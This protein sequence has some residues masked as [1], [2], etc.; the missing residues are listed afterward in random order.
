ML[1]PASTIKHLEILAR[2]ITANE[3]CLVLGMPECGKNFLYR[4]LLKKLTKYI[5]INI[6]SINLTTVE[7]QENTSVYSLLT[8]KSYE[9]NDQLVKKGRTLIIVNAGDNARINND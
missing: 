5:G 6:F 3:P 8:N 1:I 9:L 2:Y 7:F 4:Q